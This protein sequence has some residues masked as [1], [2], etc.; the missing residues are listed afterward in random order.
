MTPTQNDTKQDSTTEAAQ[1]ENGVHVENNET[2]PDYSIDPENEVTGAK[3]ILIHIGICL[4]T[5]LIGLVKISDLK[6]SYSSC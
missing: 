6:N 2:G 4:C 5:F 3:L 1:T